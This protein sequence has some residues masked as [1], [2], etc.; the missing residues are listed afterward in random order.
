MRRTRNT[1]D[2]RLFG[3]IVLGA[4]DRP[5][6]RYGFLEGAEADLSISSGQLA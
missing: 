3:G 6:R 1:I 4:C 2:E 5:P